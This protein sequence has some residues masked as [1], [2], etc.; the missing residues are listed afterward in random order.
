MATDTISGPRVAGRPVPAWAPH[1][2]ALGRVW[3]SLQQ[4]LAREPH[5]PAFDQRVRAHLGTLRQE[6]APLYGHR[7]DFEAFLVRLLHTA[8]VTASGN[9]NTI[10]SPANDGMVDG[11]ARLEDG[12]VLEFGTDWCGHCRAAQPAVQQALAQLP[13]QA[14]RSEPGSMRRML[15]RV[16]RWDVGIAMVIAG[17]VNLSMLLDGKAKLAHIHRKLGLVDHVSSHAVPVKLLG[18]E[19][20]PLSVLAH[21]HTKHKRMGV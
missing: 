6:L 17:A 21:C 2:A 3:Q 10:T 20:A 14:P 18:I 11:W 1:D 4:M 13:A 7:A 15:L 9:N 16:T 8:T 19:R 12:D 5:W